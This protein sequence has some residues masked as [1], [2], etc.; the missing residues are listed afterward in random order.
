MG[1]G[2]CKAYRILVTFRRVQKSVSGIKKRDEDK[3]EEH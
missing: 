2:A 3:P 1:T